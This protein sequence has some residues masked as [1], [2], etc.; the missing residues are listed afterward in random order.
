MTPEIETATYKLQQNSIG[1]QLP[2]TPESTSESV[3]EAATT[4][5]LDRPISVLLVRFL[6]ISAWIVG[7]LGIISGSYTITAAP[8]GPTAI[9][10]ILDKS[11]LLIQLKTV[12]HLIYMMAGWSQIIGGTL[13]W[14]I[15]LTIAQTGR[16]V[17]SIWDKLHVTSETR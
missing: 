1:D 2:L 15:L 8:E 10:T 3:A 17:L 14:A 7:I 9:D 12:N 16:A 4:T 6:S 5:V 13:A 11:G